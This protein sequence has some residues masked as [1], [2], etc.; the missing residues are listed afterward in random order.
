MAALMRFANGCFVLI[1]VCVSA[2][3]TSQ[4]FHSKYGESDIERFTPRPG[5]GLT[6]E[7][8]SDGLACRELLQPLQPLF[9]GEEQASYMSSDAISQVLDEIVPAS[10]RGK[11]IRKMVTASGCNEVEF[12]EY[13]NLSITR[14]THNCVPSSQNRDLQTTVTFKREAC[15]VQSK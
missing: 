7:F 15:R 4:E 3:Q 8:G 13:D 9:H 10:I 14:S 1:A 12:V 6:V 2:A 11:E 5:I